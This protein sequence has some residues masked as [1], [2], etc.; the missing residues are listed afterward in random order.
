MRVIKSTTPEKIE[1]RTVNFISGNT[2]HEL[3]FT[4][5]NAEEASNLDGTPTFSTSGLYKT[6][7]YLYGTSDGNIK[8]SQ[9][10]LLTD[11]IQ[12][13]VNV[14]D[15]LKVTI[16]KGDAT[17]ETVHICTIPAATYTMR[18]LTDEILDDANW[19]GGRAPIRIFDY[20]QSSTSSSRYFGLAG[21][22]KTGINQSI[23]LEPIANDAYSTLGWKS[24]ESVTKTGTSDTFIMSLLRHD[25]TLKILPINTSNKITIYEER[26][27]GSDTSA[28]KIFKFVYSSPGERET[29]G[30]SISDVDIADF[31]P[32]TAR[33][34][35]LLMVATEPLD[36]S[37]TS[38]ES[39]SDVS[40]TSKQIWSGWVSIPRDRKLDFTASARTSASDN[41]AIY[42]CGYSE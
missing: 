19:D 6:F 2:V 4:Q 26:S 41:L 22:E 15:K 1:F 40:L 8:F 14:N 12:I 5:I 17:E 27:I 24:D 9:S 28:L 31:A 35:K 18:T 10:Y 38:R 36:F 37:V 34:V 7:Y 20:G 42:A 23:Q 29:D 21:I 3:G 13:I 16:D 30:T 33:F 32:L 11:S 25:D 39:G